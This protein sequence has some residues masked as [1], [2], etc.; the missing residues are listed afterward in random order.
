MKQLFIKALLVV[1]VVTMLFSSVAILGSCSSEKNNK[2]DN[3]DNGSDNT[4]EETQDPLAYLPNK[5][6]NED[7]VVVGVGGECYR[8]SAEGD[9]VDY[10]I[11][12]RT[13]TIEARYGIEIKTKAV[14][15][16]ASWVA[17]ILKA[18]DQ[19]S[20]D[21]INGGVMTT[22]KIPLAGN[23]QDFQSIPYIDL[24]TDWWVD[25]TLEDLTLNGK[26]YLAIGDVNL[27]TIAYT[28][29]M[30]YNK[31]LVKEYKIP[32]ESG[33]MYDYA[34]TKGLWTYESMM[35]FIKDIRVDLNKDGRYNEND[36]YGLVT[37]GGTLANAYLWTWNNP[38]FKK[39][40]NTGELEFC[41]M[42][43]EAKISKML[44]NLVNMHGRTDGVYVSLTGTGPMFPNNQAVFY[45]AEFANTTSTLRD[46]DGD[47]WGI[48]P[49]P[50]YNKNQKEY[51][52]TVDGAH[53]I[54]CVPKTT[55]EQKLEKIG[56][57]TEALNCLSRVGEGNVITEFYDRGIKSK[58]L[59]DPQEATVIDTIMK[60]RVFDFGYVYLG[61]DSP[62]FWIQQMVD[63]N[64]KD[65]AGKYKTKRNELEG[66]I[67]KAY[68][69]FGLTFPGLP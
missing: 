18:N 21:L 13:R 41:L 54:L 15:D 37:P 45:N 27:S 10:A 3:S 60:N 38:I 26:T 53:S 36:L 39:N 43:N 63:N 47:D 11:Y 28:F 65:I 30:Y 7:F 48:L 19:K 62:A 67:D 31:K 20:W 58:Y 49:Y 59:G 29:C 40:Q 14:S 52:T 57:I 2:N 69:A 25:S 9:R 12:M 34:I 35:N 8:E 6:F 16:V 68:E 4:N 50:K 61:F 51:I 23:A 46:M 1:L 17:D 55:N 33:D 22:S 42:E 56:V 66:M 24:S 44:L 5:K 32:N 64:D